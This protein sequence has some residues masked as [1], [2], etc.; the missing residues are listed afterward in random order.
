LRW[1]KTCVLI[2]SLP[3]GMYEVVC[4]L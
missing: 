1:L 4:P 3:R 2:Q